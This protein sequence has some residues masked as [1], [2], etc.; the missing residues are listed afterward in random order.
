PVAAAKLTYEGVQVWR[1]KHGEP[2]CYDLRKRGGRPADVERRQRF[3]FARTP[4]SWW[5]WMDC[6]ARDREGRGNP[7]LPGISGLVMPCPELETPTQTSPPVPE[8]TPAEVTEREDRI[9]SVA[10]Q[11]GR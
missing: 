1:D 4:I 6:W 11:E 5:A 8:P 7:G 10:V 2:D 3:V 9:T